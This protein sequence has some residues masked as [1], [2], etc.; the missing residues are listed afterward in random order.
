M[1]FLTVDLCWV[2]LLWPLVEWWERLHVCSL[3]VEVPQGWLF[4]LLTLEKEV[5]K[6]WRNFLTSRC[7]VFTP[8]PASFF[9]PIFFEFEDNALSS[10]QCDWN[11][12]PSAGQSYWKLMEAS[13][14][15]SCQTHDNG[16]PAHLAAMLAIIC[17]LF[18]MAFS[19]DVHE[20]VLS[21]PVSYWKSVPTPVNIYT[22]FIIYSIIVEV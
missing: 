11:W 3:L 21:R 14:N 16:L 15:L 6:A 9:F 18:Q 10:L 2:Q 5:S 7:W 22:V 8:F 1:F 13:V 12:P 19:M 20:W 17:K 4:D